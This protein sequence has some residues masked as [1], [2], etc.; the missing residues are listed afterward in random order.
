M[1]RIS[2]GKI[3]I[4]FFRQNKKKNLSA[5]TIDIY[6]IPYRCHSLQFSIVFANFF[7]KH[8]FRYR[9]SLKQSGR[10]DY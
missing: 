1:W 10:W 3:P 2:K 6:F 9:I 5:T 7:K 4:G 8:F